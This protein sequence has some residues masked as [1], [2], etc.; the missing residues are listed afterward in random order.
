MVCVVALVCARDI[1]AGTLRFQGFP[2]R[3]S[4][5]VQTVT[6]EPVAKLAPPVAPGMEKPGA[7]ATPVDIRAGG[8]IQNA[9]AA[10]A[11]VKIS[12]P[13]TVSADEALQKVKIKADR[14]R[15]N[16][17]ALVWQEERA[18]QGS[19]TAMRS[20]AMR[21][22]SGDGVPKDEAKGMDLLRKGAAGGDSAAQKELAKR[23]PAKKE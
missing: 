4:V 9:P 10:A 19:A 3:K 23:E 6:T 16:H 1:R 20:L 15:L 5:I 12:A 7:V 13:A 22:L 14:E 2:S 17:N 18:A 21:Y 8:E 11:V